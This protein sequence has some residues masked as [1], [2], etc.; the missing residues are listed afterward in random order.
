MLW[1]LAHAQ[2]KTAS[3]LI[4]NHIKQ[5]SKPPQMQGATGSDKR[6]AIFEQTKVL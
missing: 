6:E 5:E 2:V 1:I 3:E 4:Y